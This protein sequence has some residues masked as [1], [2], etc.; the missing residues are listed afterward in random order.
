V[1][2]AR[3]KRIEAAV[4]IKRFGTFL[5]ILIL[6][7][8][9]ALTACGNDADDAVDQDVAAEPEPT[10]TP[11]EFSS[12]MLYRVVISE[13]NSVES[14]AYHPDG[15]T[16]AVGTF[17]EIHLMHASNG[18]EI[19]VIETDHSVAHLEFSPDGHHLAAGL[20]VYGVHLIDPDGA[21]EPLV[22]HG[23]NNNKVTHHPDEHHV[24]TANRDGSV[25]IWDVESGEQIGEFVPPENEWAQA[26][27]YAPNGDQV[28]LGNMKG[29][30]YL[31]D[32]ETGDL[33]HTMANPESSGQVY[34]L[35][36]S[37]NGD[38]L[39]VAGTRSSDGEV[40]RI[41]NVHDG[42]EHT[43]IHA[44]S[45]TRAVSWHPDG[46]HLA[47]GHSD[48]VHLV[49]T[50]TMDVTFSIEFEPSEGAPNWNTDLA[51]SP[52]GTHLLLSRWDGHIEMWHVHE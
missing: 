3:T 50:E 49:D 18:N 45:Q 24:A 33:I 30:I 43:T 52:D 1:G 51:Y 40:I 36:F 48:G 47:F 35:D 37:P 12:E 42:T 26:I 17:L 4:H 32:T 16:I 2:N 27:A 7:L 31:F 39:A 41:W 38:H 20:D 29:D 15:E 23:G 9:L 34:A 14:V 46:S 22:L 19:R 5:L 8:L 13:D 11:V 44:S 25:W 6:G 28:A 21:D 10:E